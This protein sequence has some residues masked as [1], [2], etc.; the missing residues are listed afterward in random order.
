VG[1]GRGPRVVHENLGEGW[2][3]LVMELGTPGDR[4]RDA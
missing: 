1:F 3:G 2:I 4:R